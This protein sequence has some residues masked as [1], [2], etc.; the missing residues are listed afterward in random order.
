MRIDGQGSADDKFSTRIRAPVC[1]R[2]AATYILLMMETTV[3][4]L[5]FWFGPAGS[6]EADGPRDFWFRGPPTLD[7]EIRERFLADHELVASGAF[8]A[9]AETADDFLAVI[10]LLD[11]FPRNMFRGTARAFATDH[12]ARDWAERALQLG[13]DHDG[14]PHRRMFFYLPFEHSEN[15]ADQEKS[16]RL[17]KAM[18][19]AN[20]TEYAEKHRDVIAEFGRFPHRN[21]ALGRDNTLDEARYLLRPDAGF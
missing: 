4:V 12:Q 18:N 20:Y 2:G 14:S 17:F 19:V 13:F 7:A 21:A 8:D 16:V 5:D 11:Q 3:R 10:V 1:A 9:A 15:L 6:P